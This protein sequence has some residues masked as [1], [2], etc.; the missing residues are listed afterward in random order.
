MVSV[1][2]ELAGMCRKKSKVN[3]LRRRDMMMN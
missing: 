3:T 2:A 1:T